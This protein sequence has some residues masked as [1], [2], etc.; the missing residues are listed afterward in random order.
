LLILI[1]PVPSLL[2]GNIST[3]EHA[4]KASIASSTQEPTLSATPFISALFGH[5][6]GMLAGDSRTAYDLSLEKKH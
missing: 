4:A 2:A 3:L 5:Q 6:R 1:W